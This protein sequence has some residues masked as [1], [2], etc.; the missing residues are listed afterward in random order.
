[1]IVFFV[2]GFIL[3]VVGAIISGVNWKNMKKRRRIIDT[4]TSRISEAPGNGPVELKGYIVPSEHGLIQTPFSG[5]PAVWARIIVQEYRSTGRSGYWATLVDETDFRPFYVDDQSGQQARVEPM[6]ANIVVD[7]VNVA[8]SGAFN[9]ASPHVRQFLA[10]R[11]LSTESWIGF[12]KRM[13]F[14][15]QAL[16]PNSPMY[17][18]GPSRRDQLDAYRGTSQLVMFAFPG[19]LGE[20]ILTNKTEDQLVSKWFWTFTAGLIVGGIGI[21]LG[22]GGVVAL[23][24]DILT[25]P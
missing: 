20:L 18:I 24:V 19:E 14:D 17:A 8:S 21:L 9:D 25:A 23:V 1:M 12:N 3:L 6:G 15:E 10:S 7:S 4:P 16:V 11:G 22:F 5:R 13:R 2:L